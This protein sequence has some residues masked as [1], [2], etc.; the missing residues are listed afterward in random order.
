MIYK[1]MYKILGEISSQRMDSC[2]CYLIKEVDSV[3]TELI[4]IQRNAVTFGER[5]EMQKYLMDPDVWILGVHAKS[6]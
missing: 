4:E 5:K 6:I 1:M 3:I 2:N